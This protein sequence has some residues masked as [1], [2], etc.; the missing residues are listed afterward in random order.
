[1]LYVGVIA[2]T[3]VIVWLGIRISD[4]A[5]AIEWSVRYRVLIDV[6]LD[7]YVR[8]PKNVETIERFYWS[9]TSAKYLIHDLPYPYRYSG[10]IIGTPRIERF[11]NV[12][13]NWHRGVWMEVK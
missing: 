6:T 7:D 12:R 11:A 13:W 5:R 3:V 4:R 10:L 8:S 9:L 1:M 2:V